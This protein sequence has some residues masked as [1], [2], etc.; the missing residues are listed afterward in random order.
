VQNVFVSKYKLRAHFRGRSFPIWRYNGTSLWKRP[1]ATEPP[2]AVSR[3]NNFHIPFGENSLRPSYRARPF[4]YLFTF[5]ETRAR[6]RRLRLLCKSRPKRDAKS[7]LPWTNKGR[8]NFERRIRRPCL[9]TVGAMDFCD[10]GAEI[11]NRSITVAGFRN[12]SDRAKYNIRFSRSR[13]LGPL[14][15]L[16]ET[17]ATY[18]TY[19]T[20]PGAPSTRCLRNG[21]R[22]YNNNRP[23]TPGR[24]RPI[25]E[26]VRWMVRDKRR[27]Y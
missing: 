11:I 10:D 27:P 5:V 2:R 25:D 19:D 1:A 6:R 17:T 21:L 23:T 15:I 4:K 3:A 12:R 16:H 8:T 20:L 22:D 14:S 24:C 9:W 7:Q 18:K 26:I 13:R